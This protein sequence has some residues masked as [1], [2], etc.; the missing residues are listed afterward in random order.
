MLASSR[1]GVWIRGMSHASQPRHLSCH[2]PANGSALAIAR[3]ATA[4]RLQRRCSET[5]QAERTCST[6]VR[7]RRNFSFY[8]RSYN[9]GATRHPCKRGWHSK[10]G[11]A[12]R[13]HPPVFL[14]PQSTPR[15]D[16]TVIIFCH[17]R[18]HFV[19]RRQTSCTSKLQQC[20]NAI[21]V[22]SH[23]FPPVL[24]NFFFQIILSR[25][26]QCLPPTH[27]FHLTDGL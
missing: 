6:V 3:N 19:M 11:G 25:Q 17:S 21:I 8:R 14:S 16:V 18:H 22:D 9:G 26:A 10:C 20:P 13:G 24:V 1:G 23:Y 2:C 7:R 27:L 15:G 5:A 4:R 12:A